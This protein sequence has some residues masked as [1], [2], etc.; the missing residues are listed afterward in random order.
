MAFDAVKNCLLDAA[1]FLRDSDLARLKSMT[2]D[3][4][5]NGPPALRP[6]F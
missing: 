6:D 2:F 5:R 4:E 1:E 3:F